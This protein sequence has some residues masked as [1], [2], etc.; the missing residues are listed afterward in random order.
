MARTRRAE[1]SG[2]EHRQRLEINQVTSG[3]LRRDDRAVDWMWPALAILA[4]APMFLDPSSFMPDDAP[5]CQQIAWNILRSGV[6]TF[7]GVTP[8]TGCSSRAIVHLGVVADSTLPGLKK[9]AFWTQA[10]AEAFTL[11]WL[12]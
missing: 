9:E 8:T 2:D 7:N 5:F 4:A 1:E 6:S 3:D 11:R 10:G 12:F